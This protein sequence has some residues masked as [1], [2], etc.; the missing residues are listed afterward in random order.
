MNAVNRAEKELAEELK[1]LARSRANDAV[2]LAFLR[3]EDQ[4]EIE[5]LQ[6]D[7]LT[8]FKRSGSGGVE[9]KLLDRVKILERLAELR[10]RNGRSKTTELVRALQKCGV[11][12]GADGD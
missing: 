7:A 3:E 12:D 4:G 2:R 6:L 11:E 1:R 9:I 10:A 5:G 8:E